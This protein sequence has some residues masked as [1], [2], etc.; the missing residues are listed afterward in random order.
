LNTVSQYEIYYYDCTNIAW[1]LVIQPEVWE[2]MEPKVS[3][4]N[5]PVEVNRS[6]MQHKVVLETLN[7]SR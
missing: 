4:I 3:V 7:L 1:C 6:D 2:R 5:F